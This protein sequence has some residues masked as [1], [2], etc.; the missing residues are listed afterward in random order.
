[1]QIVLHNFNY[2]KFDRHNFDKN[3]T[4]IKFIQEMIVF[5]SLIK[6]YYSY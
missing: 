5:S 6:M 4:A 1:M 3:D 2:F